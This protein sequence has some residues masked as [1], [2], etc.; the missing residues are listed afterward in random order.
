MSEPRPLSTVRRA[1]L[2]AMPG[3]SPFEA[4]RAAIGACLGLL[5]CVACVHFMREGWFLV[6]PL[7]ASA[8]L[9]FA[10]PNSPLAQPWSAIVGNTISAVVA[11]GVLHL[12]PSPWD[13][14]VAVGAAIAAMMVTRSLHPPGGAVA[15]L[16]VIEAET[17][18]E[19]G[20]A[21]ALVPVGAT[22]ALLV[23]SAVAYNRLTGR[24][25]PFRQP[26]AQPEAERRLGLST[27]ELRDLLGR[28]NQAANLGVA[29]L[30]RLLAAAEHEAAAHRFD[31]TL[32]SDLMTTRLITVAADTPLTRAA[33]LFQKHAIKSLPVVDRD[34]R[35]LGILLQSDLIEAL[36]LGHSMKRSP[37]RRRL[38]A[39]LRDLLA[40]DAMR[41]PAMVVTEDTP[42]GALLNRLA[43]QAV[44]IAPVM[45]GEQLA[46]IIT[47]SDVIALLL[48]GS[49]ERVAA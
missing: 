46:G 6:A 3:P 31:G 41:T 21:F 27:A 12:V 19:I 34:G 39:P 32:C 23:L 48:R 45:R 18:R 2:P 29:D 15:L 36:T 30:A 49:A 20:L 17:V 1:L 14:G 9:L 37:N 22:T 7:G 25:Y 28:F 24:V 47:R 44:Q 33:W 5:V 42:V 35:M 26:E 10:V 11:I 40:E 38:K 4:R 16:T 43:T 13:A 8:V